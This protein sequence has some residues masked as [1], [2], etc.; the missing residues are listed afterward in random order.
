M[1]VEVVDLLVTYILA[2]TLLC[3]FPCSIS[4]NQ[5]KQNQSP[6]FIPKNSCLKKKITSI[7]KKKTHTHTHTHTHKRKKGK[8][9]ISG[10]VVRSLLSNPKKRPRPGGKKKEKKKKEEEQL[11][12]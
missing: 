1:L 10:H 12:S 8:K 6:K 9:K 2:F 3:W 11:E 7:K 4:I 5:K